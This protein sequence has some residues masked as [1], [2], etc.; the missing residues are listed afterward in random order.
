MRR[1]NRKGGGETVQRVVAAQLGGG[2]G[3]PSGAYP[4]GVITE[5]GPGEPQ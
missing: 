1:L 3:G 2:G 5:R 4:L